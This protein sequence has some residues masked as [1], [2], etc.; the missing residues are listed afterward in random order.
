M[1]CPDTAGTGRRTIQNFLDFRAGLGVAVEG[2]SKAMAEPQH[3]PWE[4]GWKAGLRG[5][6]WGAPRPETTRP[7]RFALL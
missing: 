4:C 3:G 6:P 5:L 7:L 2:S 1:T